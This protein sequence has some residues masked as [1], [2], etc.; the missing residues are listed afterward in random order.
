MKFPT[1]DNRPE[2][3]GRDPYLAP[4]AGELERRRLAV[5]A[6]RRRLLRG[7]PETL[8]EFASGQEYYGLH[9]R[10]GEWVFRE[11]APHAEAITL[12]GEMSGWK[13]ATL[14]SRICPPP[15]VTCI[16]MVW[17]ANAVPSTPSQ[18]M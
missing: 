17:P 18:G 1:R 5:A 6:V 15:R 7:G 2:P 12:I 4:Y 10:D 16:C 9:F 8:A 11:W 3:F 14:P 13:A